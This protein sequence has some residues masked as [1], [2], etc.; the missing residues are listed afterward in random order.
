M[1]MT[2]KMLDFPSPNLIS[3]F[4]EFHISQRIPILQL[5]PTS[6]KAL[7]KLPISLTISKSLPNPMYVRYS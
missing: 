7:S 6:W 3:R 2:F 5:T 4:W 1:L